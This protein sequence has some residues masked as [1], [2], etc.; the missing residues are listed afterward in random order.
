VVLLSKRS[1]NCA[2]PVR[3][4]SVQVLLALRVCGAVQETS[5]T[6]VLVVESR[7]CSLVQ[8]GTINTHVFVAS[9]RV[10]GST[11][12]T[13]VVGA[14]DTGSVGVGVGVGVGVEVLETAGTRRYL[15]VG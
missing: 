4:G 1:G 3:A 6:Q 5:A 9:S 2:G 15:L 12:E 7:N 11:H 14:A 13:G 8:V 10:C